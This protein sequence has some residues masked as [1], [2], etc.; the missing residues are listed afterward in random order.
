MYE[1]KKEKITKLLIC[2]VTKA[3]NVWDIPHIGK[4]NLKQQ[5]CGFHRRIQKVHRTNVQRGHF[6]EN[7]NENYVYI[8]LRVSISFNNSNVP[9]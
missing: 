9:T 8:F 3:V 4:G 2:I 6:K 1:A 7:G 5:T